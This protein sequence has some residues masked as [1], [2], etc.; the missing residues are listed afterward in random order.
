ML[1]VYGGI[2]AGLSLGELGSSSGTRRAAKVVARSDIFGGDHFS[3]RT[4]PSLLWLI[5][6]ERSSH[7][8]QWRRRSFWRQQVRVVQA[9]G[10]YC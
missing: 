6:N 5:G 4:A 3:P 8:A 10:H 1:S 7:A 9:H 2:S